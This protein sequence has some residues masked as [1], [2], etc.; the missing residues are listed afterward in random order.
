MMADDELMSDKQLAELEAK[1]VINLPLHVCGRAYPQLAAYNYGRE[2]GPVDYRVACHGCRMQTFPFETPQEAYAAW[3]KHL[4]LTDAN[5][6]GHLRAENA[7]LREIVNEKFLYPFEPPIT[8]DP[9]PWC[10]CAQD[11]DQHTV[12]CPVTKARALLVARPCEQGQES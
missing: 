9:C 6:V 12:D 1:D 11:Y 5:E 7:T 4:A 8:C 3:Q 2:D 10:H